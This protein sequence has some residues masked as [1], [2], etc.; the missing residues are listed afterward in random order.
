VISVEAI[1]FEFWEFSSWSNMMS[2]TLKGD[3]D[4]LPLRI[5]PAENEEP[6]FLLP[7]PR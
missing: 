5:E 4:L 2:E 7:L 3:K 6:P 1:E